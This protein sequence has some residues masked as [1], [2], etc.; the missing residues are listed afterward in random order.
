[1]CV[2]SK[3]KR[4]FNYLVSIDEKTIKEQDCFVNSIIINDVKKISMCQWELLLIYM[5]VDVPEFSP[6]GLKNDTWQ[7][8]IKNW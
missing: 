3:R 1:M 7:K 8:R 2:C 4:S 6:S 5:N